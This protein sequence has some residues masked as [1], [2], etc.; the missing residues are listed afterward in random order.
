MLIIFKKSDISC[1]KIEASL[2]ITL[3]PRNLKSVFFSNLKMT[4]PSGER[5]T[6]NWPQWLGV[7]GRGES[8]F[9]SFILLMYLHVFVNVSALWFYFLKLTSKI[10]FS[11]FKKSVS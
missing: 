7:Q 9:S 1:G 4:N 10:Y 8:H 11:T 6:E 3:L 2:S 5:C